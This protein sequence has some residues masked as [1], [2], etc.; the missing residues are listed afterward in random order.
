MYIKKLF[1]YSIAVLAVCIACHSCQTSQT[2]EIKTTIDSLSQKWIPDLREGVA[3][4]DF[5]ANKNSIII[6]GETDC[7]DLKNELINVL[8]NQGYQVIDSL[9]T[10][11]S[12]TLGNH[13]YGVVALS[14]INLRATPAHSAELVSQALMGMPVKILKST[15]S[16]LL[17]Q[18]PDKYIAWTEKS[19]VKTMTLTEL[20]NWT[21]AKKLICTE[22]SGWIYE[23]P[24]ENGVIGDFVAGCV[25]E[26]YGIFRNHQKVSLPDGR[27]GYLRNKT[28]ED[29][30]VWKNKPEPTGDDILKTAVTVMGIPYLWG[31]TSS[32]GA[33]CSGFVQN[34][35]FRNGIILSRDASLQALHGLDVDVANDWSE[36]QKG[37][38]LFF[39]SIRNSKPR[40]THV[41][42]Y[43]GDGD[44]IHSSG[45]VKINSFDSTKV[46]FSRSLKNSL[47]LA[48]RVIGHSAEEG[49]VAIKN[50][51]LFN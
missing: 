37:D 34:V 22:T 15:E 1:F 46:N 41:G 29:C 31:G 8:S 10:L 43:K 7:H 42:I 32:K 39:G 48:K 17:V 12:K 51:Q 35:Y 27:T 38:L 24:E 16:W 3:K 5:V 47:L 4:I 20:K 36:L 18:T 11:P 50:H 25:M 30:F 2:V 49:I 33:D 40:V 45:M 9:E 6:K 26:D 44:F 21:S 23:T 14:V 19:A 28:F 13:I